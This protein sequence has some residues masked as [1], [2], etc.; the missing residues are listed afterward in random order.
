MARILL[1]C[2]SVDDLD[3][4]EKFATARLS[5][6][7]TLARGDAEVA[8]VLKTQ[9][10]HLIVRQSKLPAAADLAFA[11]KLRRQGYARPIIIITRDAGDLAQALADDRGIC[12]LE[13]PFD[14][15]ALE[16]LAAKMLANRPVPQQVFRRYSVDLPTTLETFIS[17]DKIESQMFNLSRGGAYLELGQ[18]PDVRVG[19]LLRIRVYLSELDRERTLSGRVMWV[20]PQGHAA[21]GYG[22]GLK[23]MK[24][25]D[26]LVREINKDP[27]V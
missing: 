15:N 27:Q 9:T 17:G 1:N 13:Q 6:D 12:L 26:G 3:A 25:G 14:L 2:S 5:A 4:L 19:D 24:S 20:T 7:L 23:F 11:R 21:G 22:L 10:M 8:R 18:K 16:G